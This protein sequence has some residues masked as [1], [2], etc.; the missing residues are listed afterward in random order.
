MKKIII[1]LFSILLVLFYSC[2]SNQTDKESKVIDD[3]NSTFLMEP[4]DFEEPLVRDLT[5]FEKEYQNIINP[6]NNQ[7]GNVQEEIDNKNQNSLNP[8]ENTSSTNTQSNSNNDL[9]SKDNKDKNEQAQNKNDSQKNNE[10]KPNSEIKNTPDKKTEQQ[11]ANQ[12]DK[13]I[14]NTD[15]A[16][17]GT[18]QKNTQQ[19]KSEDKKTQQ[20][21]N[22]SETSF[23]VMPEQQNEVKNDEKTSEQKEKENTP[24]RYVKLNLNETL[25]IAY[26]GSGWIYLGS[27]QEYN[28]LE[29]TGKQ[30]TK[31][32]T[33]YTLVAKKE[34][35]QI[36]HF[37][38]HDN[39]TGKFIDDYIE[40]E[41]T[42][43]K[44]SVYTIVKAPAYTD[45]V[46]KKPEFPAKS[47]KNQENFLQMQESEKDNTKLS[48]ASPTTGKTEYINSS[49]VQNT[50]E[51]L[52]NEKRDFIEYIPEEES[53]VE[54]A[55]NE[56]NENQSI[57]N[58]SYEITDASELLQKAQNLIDEK[59]Y[60]EAEFYLQKFFE[61]STEK[62][63]EGFYLQGQLFEQ[64]SS[65]KDIKKSINSYQN[66]IDNYPDSIYYDKANKRI[67]Y[68]KRFYIEIR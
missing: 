31:D 38:K 16:K 13:K 64:D 2:A 9:N 23:F 11:K 47:S 51:V 60:E 15:T 40:V 37:Y 67:I 18:E 48:P 24:S 43:T 28:N 20:K 36:H 58:Y 34:G 25:S 57:A 65:I 10:K 59:K 32:E 27:N 42:S 39:L 1:C 50:N 30:N 54:F 56:I 21:P 66:I 7:N 29:T 52:P 14:N 19:S 26:P 53:N 3:E 41:V 62:R 5:E 45:F 63:D 6:E 61:I 44:G 35:K 17:K 46:P 55:E 49:E 22:S 8:K 4:E 12:T 68:L 33:V